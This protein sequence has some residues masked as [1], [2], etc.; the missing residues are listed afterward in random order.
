MVQMFVV[1]AS[2]VFM[3][4]IIFLVNDNYGKKPYDI[5]GIDKKTITK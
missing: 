1:I 5:F 2:A 4:A 3:I